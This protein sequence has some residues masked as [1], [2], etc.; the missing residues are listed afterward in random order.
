MSGA[1]NSTT[2]TDNSYTPKTV[3]AVG[4][5]K[6]STAQSKWYGSSAYFDGTGDYLS[7]SSSSDLEMGSGDYT[8]ELW[9]YATTNTDG[10]LVFK[11][12]Y[13]NGATWLPGFGIRRLSATLMRFY[14]NTSTT[15]AGERYYDYTTT[16]NT[17]TWYH[18]AMVVSG[19]TGYAF[20]NGTLVGTLTSIGTI[21]TSTT[22]ITVGAF[23]YNIGNICFTGY[24]NDLRITKG[25][26]RYTATFTP[27]ANSFA[28]GFVSGNYYGV[29]DNYYNDLGVLLHLDTSIVTPY[30]DSST[31]NNTFTT[32]GT[33]NNSTT[34]YK[35]GNSSLY[36]D[37]VSGTYLST[38]YNSGFTFTGD[39]TIEAWVYPSSVGTGPK[40]VAS[41]WPGQSATICSFNFY[42][43]TYLGFSYGIGGSNVG[44]SGTSQALTANAWNH[45]AVTRSGTTVRFFVNGQLDA[46]TP[47]VSGS[48]NVSNA[49]LYI[50][51]TNPSEG[52]YFS[53]YIDELRITKGVARYTASF[54]PPT[55][56]FADNVAGDPDFN[57]VSLLMHYEPSASYIPK[58][59]TDSSS[60]P[61]QISAG[62]V[63][64]SPTTWKFGGTSGY[65]TGSSS[66]LRI[67]YNSNFTFG[68]GDFTVECWINPNRPASNNTPIV[69]IWDGTSTT[70]QSWYL[71][72]YSTGS[73]GFII[74]VASADTSIFT[75]DGAIPNN[76]WT[77]VAI[78]RSGNNWYMFINGIIA[79]T[80]TN[81]ST[82]SAGNAFLLVGAYQNMVG[83]DTW[84]RGYIDDLRITKGVAR[85][86]S[87]FT[88]P[89]QAYP[90][91]IA[92]DP[93]FNS[94]SLLLHFDAS[95]TSFQLVDSGPGAKTVSANSAL[96]NTVSRFGTSALACPNYNSYAVVPYS[97]DWNIGSYTNYTIEF[98][99][100]YAQINDNVTLMA[101]MS[102]TTNPY[103]RLYQTATAGVI[104]GIY[105]VTVDASGNSSTFGWNTITESIAIDSWVNVAIVKSG[106]TWS[107]YLNGNKQ[108]SDQTH[109]WSVTPTWDL[110]IGG[111][112]YSA[113]SASALTLDDVR[114]TKGV[115]RYSS[116]FSPLIEPF[117][118]YQSTLAQAEFDPLLRSSI[119]NLPAYT[120]TGVAIAEPLYKSSIANLPTV[121]NQGAATIDN[122]LFSP[123]GKISVPYGSGTK[124]VSGIVVNGSSAPLSR[125]VIAYSRTTNLPLDV[126]TSNDLTGEFVLQVPNEDVVVVC[127]PLATDGVNAE[128]YD[129]VQPVSLPGPYDGDP[130]Y[131]NVKLLLHMNGT[132]GSTAFTDNSSSPKTVNPV[133][134]AQIS[135]AQSKWGGGS[136]LFDGSGDY[137]AVPYNSAFDFGTGNYTIECWV[138]WN[139]VTNAGI[140]H[141]YPGSPPPNTANGTALGYDGTSLQIYAVGNNHAR[142]YAITAGTWYH[143]AVVRAS[144]AVRLYVNGIVQGAAIADGGNYGG[145]NIYIGLYYGTS[146]T[147][148][149]HINDFRATFG[150]ARYTTNFTP[151]TGPFPNNG[152]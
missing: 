29:G 54:T 15:G 115:A 147:L 91:S 47:T 114:I 36:L 144:G 94:V 130:S 145:N 127:L 93:D 17:N 19:G 12:Q 102:S 39:F 105:F 104:T 109:T 82:M 40:V 7:T 108:G 43:N 4:D 137:L 26:A 49:P 64:P 83:S 116:N 107:L 110:T 63:S 95:P 68:A 65:F 66:F 48:L 101:Q 57:S 42:F 117:Y 141:L 13:Q 10:G 123:V 77:H 67:P 89:T 99:V 22:G 24:I 124:Y 74:D 2:F 87:N 148:N 103:W 119:A 92:G 79:K 72:L 78:T 111:A 59:F 149:G 120:R 37:G 6:I 150:V 80:A 61:K 23:P 28:S 58:V 73:L 20:V 46:T 122:L 71:L 136:G 56:A 3:T 18:I 16:T 75:S 140:Y 131:D 143:L 125:T 126:T 14:F 142:P 132:N 62:N 35:Y 9:F 81:S 152:L 25:V 88:L 45:I 60:S 118:N 129:R 134:N 106:N 53:G 86:T 113:A 34:I 151:P 38:P 84:Y 133:G 90:D 50:G 51:V 41:N 21:G 85:Y 27:P 5:T 100:S 30:S 96:V 52:S 112:P 76:V 146:F 69:S 121:L 97:T 128:I 44:V 55:Q 70:P 135:T 139:T 32:S 11:G 1:N 98:W 8:V 33:T 138:R 31:S